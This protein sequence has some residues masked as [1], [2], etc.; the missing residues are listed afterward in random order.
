MRN[1]VFDF[2]A[3][4]FLLLV[5]IIVHVL[6]RLAPDGYIIMWGVSVMSKEAYEELL[7]LMEDDDGY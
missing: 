7:E 1:K 5:T 6:Q 4:P 3:T 2:F